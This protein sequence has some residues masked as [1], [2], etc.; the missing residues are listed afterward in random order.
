MKSYLAPDM[1]LLESMIS[2]IVRTSP[3]DFSELPGYGDSENY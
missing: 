1:E 2:D 3:P